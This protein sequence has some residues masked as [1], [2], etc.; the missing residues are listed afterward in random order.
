MT[1]QTCTM[2]GDAR[3]STD[4]RSLL[5][6]GALLPL[7]ILPGC[8]AGGTLSLDE[9]I[10]RLLSLSSQRALA[11]LMAAGGFY[12]SEI[13]RID[14]PPQLGGPGAG[15]VLASLLRT[16]PVR[17]RLL[18]QVN[19]AAEQGA[20]R[21]APLVADAVRSISIADALAVVRGGPTAATDLLSA[22]MG[23][24]L[25]RAM[26]PGIT[27]G[28]MLVDNA[29]VAQAL[30]AASGIDLAG[31]ANDV[32]RKASTAIF[33]AI[34]AEEAAIRANPRAT[35]DPLLIGVLTLAR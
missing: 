8:A 2:T 19:R 26:L 31:L 13:A 14:L 3:I 5:R 21:A 29:I 11:S 18:R 35:G 17:D 23:D 6:A 27:D 15:S 4:R 24:S 22:A 20:E 1:D 34:G 28:L 7:L 32:N 30:R 12:D 9:A 16:A 25:V 33:R 10:R